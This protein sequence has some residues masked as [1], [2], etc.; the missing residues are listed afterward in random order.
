MLDLFVEYRGKTAEARFLL[1]DV[2]NGAEGA[3]FSRLNQSVL[4]SFHD[5]NTFTEWPRFAS[6]DELLAHNRKVMIVLDTLLED[7]RKA[8]IDSRK[9]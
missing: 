2:D 7:I 3:L 6:I 5:I 9:N 4:M 8:H 1:E